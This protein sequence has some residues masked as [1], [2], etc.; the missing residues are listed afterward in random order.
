MYLAKLKIEGFRGLN[1]LELNF[2]PGLNVLIGPNNVGKTAIVDALRA[3]LSTTDDGALQVDESDLYIDS[4]GKKA[5]QVAFQYVFR[6]L[7]TDEEA[8]FL[9][10]QRFPIALLLDDLC[11][12]RHASI[13][14]I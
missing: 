9:F 14:S 11:G 3:L 6:G 2:R 5:Q 4:A 1:L 13:T 7:T 10:G 8:D 12:Q